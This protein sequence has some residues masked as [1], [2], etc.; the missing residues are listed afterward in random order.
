MDAKAFLPDGAYPVN[1]FK[2]V[3]YRWID[4]FGCLALG[5][6]VA[7]YMHSNGLFRPDSPPW[8]IAAVLMG[9]IAYLL[10]K[11]SQSVTYVL[12]GD[13]LSEDRA[14]TRELRAMMDTNTGCALLILPLSAAAVVWGIA[15]LLWIWIQWMLGADVE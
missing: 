15:T 3:A 11:L 2:I 6:Y 1:R 5:F 8:E 13:L 4:I 9:V 12:L 14:I 10:T 7:F